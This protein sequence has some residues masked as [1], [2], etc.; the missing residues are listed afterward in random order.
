MALTFD[1]GLGYS[2]LE[3]PKRGGG[4]RT[5]LRPVSELDHNLKLLR[6][7]IDTLSSYSPPEWVHGFVPKR[8]IVTNAQ[9]HLSKEIVLRLDLSAFFESI[10]KSAVRE[11]MLRF[12]FSDDASTLISDCCCIHGSLPAGFSTSPTL[13]NMVFLPTDDALHEWAGSRTLT[14]TRYAD[15]LTFS[16]T[17]ITDD[18]CAEIARM[19]SSA[20]YAVNARKTRFMRRG[21]PQYVTGL[22]VGESDQPHVPRRMKRLLRQQA[23]YIAQYGYSEA[24]TRSSRQFTPYQLRGWINYMGTLHPELAA[25][26]R[27]AIFARL[28]QAPERPDPSDYWDDLLDELHIPDDF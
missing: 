20:G 19:L 8:S 6:R 7:G 24:Q 27:C 15:D 4:S 13:S 3:V 25:R 18:D 9:A 26:L 22:Y 2:T 11:A 23:Y 12:G 21:G 1:R 28:P 10:K 14:Y 5:V 17:D 16:G